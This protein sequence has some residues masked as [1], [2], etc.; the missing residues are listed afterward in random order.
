MNIPVIILAVLIIVM[1]AAFFVYSVCNYRN[2]IKSSRF[3]F[4]E[5]MDLCNLPVITFVVNNRKLNFI[6]DTGADHS[7]INKS[8]ADEISLDKLDK[9]GKAYGMEGNYKPIEYANVV[10]EYNGHKY[11]DTVLIVDMNNAFSNLK[12]KYGVNI[13]GLLGNGFFRKY[14][15][16]LDFQK[17]IAYSKSRLF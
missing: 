13:H 10:F 11:P 17:L 12:N 5:T 8:I 4:R 1:G 6:L 3:S 2:F 7:V 16:M 9:K 15:Y 14:E